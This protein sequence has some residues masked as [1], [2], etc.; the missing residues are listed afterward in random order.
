MKKGTSGSD[1]V[2]ALKVSFEFEIDLNNE[3][4]DFA[5][6]NIYM[7]LYGERQDENNPVITNNDL[8][9]SEA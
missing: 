7:M 9:I 4:H 2:D 8:S 6:A 1:Q 5:M 3:W